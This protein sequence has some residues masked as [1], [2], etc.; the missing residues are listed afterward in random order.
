MFKKHLKFLLVFLLISLLQ[1]VGRYFNIEC[2]KIFTTPL[3]VIWLIIFLIATTSLKGR[4]HKRLFIGMVLA[5]IGDLLLLFVHLDEKYFSY[6]LA[7]F[8]LSHISYTR[9]FYLDF[10]SAPDLDKKG[11]RLA[12]IFCAVLSTV[13]FFYLRPYLGAMRVPV[14]AYTLVISLMMMMAVFRH[15]RVNVVS[16][17]LI[18]VGVACFM[19]S[20]ALVA[21]QKFVIGFAGSNVAIMATYMTAQY[22]ITLG[23]VERQLIN[24]T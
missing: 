18:F 3:I 4:F 22:L 6:G 23:A 11:A 12:I 7:A 21:Y 2:L 9:A 20:D 8:M 19:L 16:F 1:L 5:L 13:F 15:L 14:L 24:K 10:K 17:N